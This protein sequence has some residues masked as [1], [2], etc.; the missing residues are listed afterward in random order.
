MINGA[1]P[2][3][4]I[5]YRCLT[6][7]RAITDPKSCESCRI[8]SMGVGPFFVVVF[9]ERIE[10]D[11]FDI[12]STRTQNLIKDEINDFVQERVIEGFVEPDMEGFYKTIGIN[13]LVIVI[14]AIVYSYC[15]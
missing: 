2:T 13:V 10:L 11:W 5:L 8:A 9:F 6:F 7:A 15:A 4:R 3:L 14:F 12:E 1:V